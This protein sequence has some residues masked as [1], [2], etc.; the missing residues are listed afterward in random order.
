MFYEVVYGII[1]S[2]ICSIEKQKGKSMQIMDLQ[3]HIPKK[4]DGWFYVKMMTDPETMAYNAPWF[5][6]DGCIPHPEEEWDKLL[7]SWIGNESKRFYAF[8]KRTSDGSFIGDVNYH[9]NPKQDCFDMGVVIYA[10]ERGKG[11]A[12]QGLRLL[13][14]RAFRVNRISKLRN[15]FE[16]DRDAAYRAHKAVGFKELGIEDGCYLLEITRED[17]LGEP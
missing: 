17:Y 7:A 13:L 1:I 9:Y 10:P 6:P 8:L 4:E 12:K 2:T 14:D 11:Y 15:S 16:T 3:L 5:P